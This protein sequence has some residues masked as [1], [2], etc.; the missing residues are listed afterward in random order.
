MTMK[1]FITMMMVISV[2]SQI[3]VAQDKTTTVKSEIELKKQWQ[4]LQFRLNSLDRE[5]SAE[6][7]K[8]TQQQ[9]DFQSIEEYKSWYDSI[10]PMLKDI[11]RH[12]EEFIDKSFLEFIKYM[13][14]QKVNIDRYGLIANWQKVYPESIDGL[15]LLFLNRK[16]T[17]FA[18]DNRLRYPVII[19]TFKGE[20]KPVGEA[21][22]LYKKSFGSLNN[23]FLQMFSDV[24]IESIEFENLDNMYWKTYKK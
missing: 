23:E 18:G 4:Q 24:Q 16:K 13:S 7:L 14:S 15:R 20:K 2:F 11:E 1:N 6:F 5:L 22:L 3:C 19:L 9:P 17:Q 10:V 8:Y 12:K 21:Q